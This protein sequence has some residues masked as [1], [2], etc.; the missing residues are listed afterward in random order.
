[1]PGPVSPVHNTWHAQSNSFHHGR[2]YE[3]GTSKKFG[4]LGQW[5]KTE[6]WDLRPQTSSYLINMTKI[7]TGEKSA[8]LTNGPYQTACRQ[9]KVTPCLLP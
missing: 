3:H 9:T 6:D 5:H 1:M 7:Q 2:I 4:H 8:S